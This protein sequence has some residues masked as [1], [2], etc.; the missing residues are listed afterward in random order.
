MLLLKRE[1]ATLSF[2]ILA[3]AISLFILVN[4]NRNMNQPV[5]SATIPVFSSLTPTE[6][7]PGPI[8]SETMNSPDGT[9]TLTMK[10]Q[11]IKDIIKYSIY[12]SDKSG[13]NE[14]LIFEKEEHVFQN[15]TIPYNTWSPDNV[16]FFLKEI[17]PTVSNYYVFYASSDSFPDN[18]QYVNIQDLFKQKLPELILT[19]V[20]GWAA[21]NLL[22]ANT[23]T[24]QGKLAFSFWFDVPSQSFI[25]LGTRFN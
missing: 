19:D 13:T 25:Q 18:V 6:I 7:P 15:F 22:I 1:L 5:F 2:I 10:K 9:K 8:Q 3:T 14:K 4:R 21:P 23:N 24:Y 20:T 16:Y 12:T 11:Q 17:T